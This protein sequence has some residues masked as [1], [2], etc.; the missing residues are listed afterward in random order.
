MEG[1][2]PKFHQGKENRFLALIIFHTLAFSNYCVTR[3]LYISV[4]NFEHGWITRFTT[5]PE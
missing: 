2:S 1:V 4:V 3:S 5:H